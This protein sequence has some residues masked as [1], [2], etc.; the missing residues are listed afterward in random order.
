[1]IQ[2]AAAL[3]LLGYAPGAALYRIPA[4]DRAR[5]ERLDAAERVFWGVM[6]S[7]TWSL[8]VALTNAALTLAILI[9]WR[10]GLRFG[11]ATP[12]GAIAIA[13]IALLALVWWLHPPP[14]EYILGGKDPGVYVNAGI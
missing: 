11:N 2:Q 12:P 10:T 3:I 14:A 8:I 6:L 4:A 13:P 7:V 9:Y 1:M 5:R